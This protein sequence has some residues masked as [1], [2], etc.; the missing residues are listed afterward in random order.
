MVISAFN[1]HRMVN[2]PPQKR[3]ELYILLSKNMFPRCNFLLDFSIR[4]E[5]FKVFCL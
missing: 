1:P 3:I 2:I 5:S 4:N